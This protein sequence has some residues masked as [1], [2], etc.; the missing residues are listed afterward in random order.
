MVTDGRGADR[1]AM[2]E[3]KPELID[4]PCSFPVKVMGRADSSFRRTVLEIVQR[5]A[6]EVR[7]SDLRY[8]DSSRGR[9][10]SITVEI[11][12]HSRRQLDSLYR[13]L[14]AHES[15]LMTL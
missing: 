11:E 13:E 3:E 10:L 9:F 12:A 1:S 4:F 6:P 8:Q 14:N 5:H 15:V 2:T 7:E